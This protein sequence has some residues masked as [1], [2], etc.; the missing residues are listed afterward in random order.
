MVKQPNTMYTEILLTDLANSITA[1][2]IPKQI[3]KYGTL[4]SLAYLAARTMPLTLRCPN[5][6]G[7]K[8]QAALCKYQFPKK[9]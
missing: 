2:C 1:I 7:T 4:F 9:L 3:P 8:T 5:P 6:P